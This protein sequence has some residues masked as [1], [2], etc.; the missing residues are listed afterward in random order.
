MAFGGGRWLCVNIDA[1][2]RWSG[3][4]WG[5]WVAVGAGV[6][7][8]AGGVGVY[9]RVQESKAGQEVAWGV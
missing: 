6:G 1:G 7:D 8:A 4:W 5:R 2:G 3:R 9:V